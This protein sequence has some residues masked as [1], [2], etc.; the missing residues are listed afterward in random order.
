MGQLNE[1]MTA[2]ANAIRLKTGQ[3]GKLSLDNMITA[4]DN[5]E[6]G[7]SLLNLTKGVLEHT[8]VEAV[9][10]NTITSLGDYVFAN[11]ATLIN[12]S[13]PETITSIGYRTFFSCTGLTHVTLPSSIVTMGFQTFAN[14]S[15]LTSITCLATT[16]PT[17]KTDTF[18]NNVIAFYVPSASVDAYKTATNWAAY[19]D[20]IQAIVE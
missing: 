6:S 12:I 17:I 9:I 3:T 18:T 20:L 2:L 1:K 11:C 4:V 10:P 19:A 5:M 13:L 16:P 14:C 8:I 7:A 15:G